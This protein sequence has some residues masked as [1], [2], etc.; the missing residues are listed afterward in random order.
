MQQ[1]KMLNLQINKNQNA[2]LLQNFPNDPYYDITIITRCTSLHLA[3]AHLTCESS[4]FANL[5]T[6]QK[7]VDLAHLNDKYLTAVL[8]SLYGG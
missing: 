8:R 7:E 2:N 5:P 1:P 3:S 6:S 4:F